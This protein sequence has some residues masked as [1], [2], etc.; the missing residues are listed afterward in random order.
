MTKSEQYYV[1][2]VAMA[3]R[4]RC[5]EGE[6]I[7]KNIRKIN[8]ETLQNIVNNFG[9]RLFNNENCDSYFKLNEECTSFDICIGNDIKEEDQ[10]ITVL[11]A[12]GLTF[13]DGER[14]SDNS[15][16]NISEDGLIDALKEYGIS[17]DKILLFAR[18][19]LMPENLYDQ[20]MVENTTKDGKFDCIEMAK[21]FGTGYM[22]V[23]TRGEDL[24]KWH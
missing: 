1:S 17:Y 11:T 5:V 8:F 6:I 4:K 12:L 7:D 9:G 23:L 20:S 10:S 3:A 2:K 24:G 18:E 22:K 16:I 15:I 13:F 21:D 14:L 19:F